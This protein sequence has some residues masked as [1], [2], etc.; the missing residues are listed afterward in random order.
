M[1]GITGARWQRDEQLHLTL[2]FIGEVNPSAVDDIVSALSSVRQKPVEVSFSGFGTFQ[3]KERVD[4]LWLGVKPAEVLT[5]L[6]RKID[7]SLVRLGLAPEHRA[8]V[9][10]VTIARF[11]RTVGDLAAFLE[12]GARFSCPAFTVDSFRLY[13]SFTGKDG[14]T[15]EPVQSFRLDP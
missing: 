6:H 3:R 7:R 5:L 12:T 15:Y 2:R 13:A 8:Y 1:G 14:S 9:P 10:H 11:G 4:T